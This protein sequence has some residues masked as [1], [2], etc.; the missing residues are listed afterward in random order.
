VILGRDFA[1]AII[2]S[3]RNHTTG[4]AFR[5]TAYRQDFMVGWSTMDSSS[6]GAYPDAEGALGHRQGGI[7]LPRIRRSGVHDLPRRLAC[8]RAAPGGSRALTRTEAA[9]LAAS[10]AAEAG[11]DA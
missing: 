6:P 10:D 3:V 8:R 5:P 7:G 4:V 1:G 11:M 9:W 2:E